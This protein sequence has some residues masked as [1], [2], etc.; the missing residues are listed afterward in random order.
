MAARPRT[1]R[2]RWSE[3]FKERVVA[4]ASELDMAASEPGT[5]L[6]K[7]EVTDTVSGQTSRAAAT[8]SI[9]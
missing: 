4:D 6:L 5:Q 3:T 7:I 8:F 2:R 9:R 1:S